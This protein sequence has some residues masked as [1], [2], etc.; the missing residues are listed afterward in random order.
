MLLL[1]S[2][3]GLVPKISP[4]PSIP[5]FTKSVGEE[6]PH[7]RM[8]A[9]RCWQAVGPARQMFEA[10]ASKIA[11][12]LSDW[13]WPDDDF[14]AWSM[15]MI[16]PSEETAVPTLIVHG[17]NAAAR[18]SVC[19]LI[20]SS[21]ILQHHN[22]RLDDRRLAPDFNR[23]D[24]LQFMSGSTNLATFESV[25]ALP[26]SSILIKR[27]DGIVSKAT[28]GIILQHERRLFVTTVAHAFPPLPKP[29][30]KGVSFTI[31][32]GVGVS[33]GNP[34]IFRDIDYALLEVQVDGSTA[35]IC[36]V[37][38]LDHVLSRICSKPHDAK[39][40]GRLNSDQMCGSL[41]GTPTFIRLPGTKGFNEVW[42]FHSTSPLEE[43]DCGSMLVGS[44]DG[45][46]YGHVVVGSHSSHYAYILPAKQLLQAALQQFQMSHEPFGGNQS[47]YSSIQG[48]STWNLLDTSCARKPVATPLSGGEISYWGYLK[49]RTSELRTLIILAILSLLY[50][51]VFLSLPL[52]L[53][54]LKLLSSSAADPTY[55]LTIGNCSFDMLDHQ[56]TQSWGIPLCVNETYSICLSP[57]TIINS[58]F[59]IES[60]A[61]EN[62][63]PNHMSTGKEDSTSPPAWTLP[64]II[65]P[66]SQNYT[67]PVYLADN[68]IHRYKESL[69]SQQ[70]IFE[71]R[72]GGLAVGHRATASHLGLTHHSGFLETLKRAGNITTRRFGLDVGNQLAPRPGTLILGG[73][74]EICSTQAKARAQFNINLPDTTSIRLQ[75]ASRVCQL[76]IRIG[77]SHFHARSKLKSLEILH[78]SLACIEPYANLFRLPPDDLDM[79]RR[80]FASQETGFL[81]SANA[82][83]S[84][85]KPCQGNST[86]LSEGLLIPGDFED[87]T[88]LSNLSLDFT[89][90]TGSG[91]NWRVSIPGPSLIRPLVC[92]S[93]D[94]STT[95]N[96][97]FKELAIHEKSSDTGN[98]ILG[99]AFLS[100]LY[101]SVDYDKGEFSLTPIKSADVDITT[102][103]LDTSAN[104]IL[105]TWSLLIS[106]VILFFWGCWFWVVFI[107]TN[108]FTTLL[109][110]LGSPQTALT[111]ALWHSTL[112]GSKDPR[113]LCV[114]IP[115]PPAELDMWM[116]NHDGIILVDSFF[117]IGR[118]KFK[119]GHFVT[120]SLRNATLH[121]I[122]PNGDSPRPVDPDKHV[123]D[124]NIPPDQFNRL[125]RPVSLYGFW[126]PGGLVACSVSFSFSFMVEAFINK[127]GIPVTYLALNMLFAWLP[128]LISLELARP[129][130]LSKGFDIEWTLYSVLYSTIR[131][132][133]S[134][135]PAMFEPKRKERPVMRFSAGLLSASFVT[136]CILAAAITG[137]PSLSRSASGRL[138]WGLGLLIYDLL[139]TAAWLI[140]MS[141]KSGR[142]LNNLAATFKLI[143]I[144]TL[145]I[146]MFMEVLSAQ[147]LLTTSQ[148]AAM[149]FPSET[150]DS[151]FGNDTH[152]Y[153][154]SWCSSLSTNRS[155]PFGNDTL[156]GYFESW[157]LSR[158]SNRPPGSERT[159]HSSYFFL[160]LWQDNYRE[161]AIGIF[162]V[163]Q[164]NIFLV[165]WLYRHTRWMFCF[166]SILRA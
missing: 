16:G 37:P 102:G 95:T 107:R 158:S 83:W 99:Q 36:H 5:N 81:S 48:F 128:L 140:L 136:L 76:P 122:P 63:S 142:G 127:T 14:I 51:L 57:S 91:T 68:K 137:V 64:L 111:K 3:L 49:A 143:A 141:G 157:C 52:S 88:S 56:T 165:L 100:L 113:P 39:I 109:D 4:K 12:T 132:G 105:P 150:W 118:A 31:T 87:P 44:A 67:I 17:E 27:D 106:W 110:W 156:H 114:I 149:S 18:K 115:P 164:L 86:R 131:M 61:A 130:Y 134:S 98:V 85:Q 129:G 108:H 29:G 53:V 162:M 26:G 41:S 125:P 90:I 139:G 138:F 119:T 33:L 43:G 135:R 40:S 66:G 155:F 112:E 126:I 147:F 58:A 21:G 101:L 84:N 15:F 42:T 121:R 103:G 123:S 46:I 28:V 30:Q 160:D 45:Q 146:I 153:F 104:S 96:P 124:Q 50:L 62:L 78:D 34:V 11:K 72:R 94:G 166:S 74:D 73:W 69:G 6:Y 32:S 23:V 148:Q 89:F 163:V 116:L 24:P 80:F 65:S 152:G 8:G 60:E 159:I 145:V 151:P 38:S 10:L 133:S 35:S 120:C 144:L 1:R 9:N 55:H 92:V 71:S 19:K 82:P 22:V 117:G 75:N 154:R 20:Q 161:L 59:V 25:Q 54:K 93:A 7:A 77:V 79:V 13:E 70:S 97:M 2:L 47:V